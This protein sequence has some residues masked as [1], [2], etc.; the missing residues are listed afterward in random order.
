MLPTS[1]NSYNVPENG[2]RSLAAANRGN[3]FM[4]AVIRTYSGQ[5]AKELFETLA[6]DK[7][8]VEKIMRS[9]NG[10]VSYTIV[11]TEE[12]GCTLSVFKDKAGTDESVVKAGEWVK[13]NAPSVGVKPPV[14]T[15]GT[16]G[17]HAT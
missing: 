10:F 15:E 14:V 9:I 2:E 1:E 17:L 7:A 6:N 8:E 5:G 16:I 13:K 4:Y 3:E 12:G 11:N